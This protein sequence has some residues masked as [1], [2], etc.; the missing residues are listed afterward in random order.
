[1]TALN[2]FQFDGIE[3]RPA[4]TRDC[5]LATEWTEQD[6]DHAGRVQ[7]KFWLSQGLAVDSYL[8]SDQQGPLLFFRA[9]LSVAKDRTRQCRIHM[10]F[11]PEP[12]AKGRT[13]IAMTKG[14]VWIELA[15]APVVDELLFD[16][17]NESLIRFCVNRLG[18][19]R[20][21]DILRKRIVDHGGSR[22]ET[23]DV[24]SDQRADPT[25]D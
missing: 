21:G 11:R 19:V 22:K 8:V 25:P 4:A 14:L 15:L 24:R 7:P 1:M 2:T 16:S 9:D 10:Q 17:E 20:E 6:P 13:A 12:E 5:A 3:L 23:S 18:F